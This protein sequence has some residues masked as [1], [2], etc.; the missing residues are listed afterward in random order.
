MMYLLNHFGISL[1]F[2]CEQDNDG[3]V[4]D[5]ELLEEVEEV[6]QLFFCKKFLCHCE[7]IEILIGNALY[8]VLAKPGALNLKHLTHLD[9]FYLGSV[10]EVC[11][12]VGTLLQ[13][14]FHGMENI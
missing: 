13:N 8:L 4:V 10:E 12:L 11:A 14:L 7:D 2:L 3:V 5:A 1:Y 9:G 6:C